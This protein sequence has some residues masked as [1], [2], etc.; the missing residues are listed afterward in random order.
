MPVSLVVSVV[1]FLLGIAVMCGAIAIWTILHDLRVRTPQVQA[2]SCMIQASPVALLPPRPASSLMG[3]RRNVPPG[4][5]SLP[6]PLPRGSVLGTLVP[7]RDE[8]DDDDHDYTVVDDGVTIV[9]SIKV[10]A[11]R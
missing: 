5:P 11:R 8:D 2:P 7:E 1:V 6:A 10:T 4:V 9:R 3:P